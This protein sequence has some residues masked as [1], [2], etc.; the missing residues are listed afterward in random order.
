MFLCF[1]LSENLLSGIL[2][3][4]CCICCAALVANFA[5][6]SS[7]FLGLRLS[8]PTQNPQKKFQFVDTPWNLR[9]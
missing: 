5:I 3:H 2:L 6:A 4:D 1:A 9:F 8:Q 7:A